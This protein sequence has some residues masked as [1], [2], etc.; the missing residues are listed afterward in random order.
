MMG[1]PGT[2]SRSRQASCSSPT[3]S[4]WMTSPSIPA[5]ARGSRTSGSACA[6]RSVTAHWARSAPTA[7]AGFAI[8]RTYAP[9]R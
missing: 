6:S 1:S 4:H 2:Y 8:F 5:R 3:G 7:V 9:T